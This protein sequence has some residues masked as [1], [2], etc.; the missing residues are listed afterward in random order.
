MSMEAMKKVTEA[1]Q[2]VQSR[3]EAAAVEGRQ[4]IAQAQRDGELLVQQVRQSAEA[5]VRELM[6]QTEAAT[7]EKTKQVLAEAEKKC[8]QFRQDARQRLDE[9]ASFIAGRVVSD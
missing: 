1:E 4:M 7:A 3:R 6:A 5:Q 2:L 9:A 8:V